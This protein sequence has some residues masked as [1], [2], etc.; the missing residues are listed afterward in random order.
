L[1]L[2]LFYRAVDTV[3]TVLADAGKPLCGVIEFSGKDSMRESSPFAF[4]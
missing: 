2:K 1:F 4:K 3:D